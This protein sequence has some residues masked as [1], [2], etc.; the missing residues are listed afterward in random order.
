LPFA[1]VAIDVRITRLAPPSGGDSTQPVTITNLHQSTEQQEFRGPNVSTAHTFVNG[2][3]V[4]QA[5]N[6]GNILFI[7]FC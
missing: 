3:S 5:L 1:K 7:P 4:I 2:E 6:D